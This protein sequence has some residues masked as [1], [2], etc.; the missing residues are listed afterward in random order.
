M[1]II[2]GIFLPMDI[3]IDRENEFNQIL[4]NYVGTI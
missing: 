1:V 3:E 4:N 2:L